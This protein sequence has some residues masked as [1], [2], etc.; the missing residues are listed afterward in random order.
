MAVKTAALPGLAAKRSALLRR[1]N[2]HYCRRL[3][4]IDALDAAASVA[5]LT[6]RQTVRT[7]ERARTR[8]GR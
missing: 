5:S 4:E 8:G 3:A 6:D 7:Y 1:L 2:G